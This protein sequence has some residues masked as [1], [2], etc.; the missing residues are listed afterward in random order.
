MKG[1]HPHY[2]VFENCHI[3]SD[4]VSLQNAYTV[5]EMSSYNLIDIVTWQNVERPAWFYIESQK[6][7]FCFNTFYIKST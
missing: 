6:I 7:K 4:I 3:I 5:F 2:M 1:S